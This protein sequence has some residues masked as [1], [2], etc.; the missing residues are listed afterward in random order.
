MS[1]PKPVTVLRK[2]NRVFN[3]RELA[4]AYGLE[5]D[6]RNNA[7]KAIREDSQVRELVLDVLGHTDI[8]GDADF[9]VDYK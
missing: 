5:K 9:W 8:E 7:V 1:K 3:T 4:E 2:T 6:N